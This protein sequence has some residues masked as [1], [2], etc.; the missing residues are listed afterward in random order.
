MEANP[1]EPRYY[2]MLEQLQVLDFALMEL[3]LYLD[4]HPEDLRAI[5]QFNQ[6]TQ[7]SAPGWP[8]NFRSCTA[9]CRTLAAPTPNVRGNG[10]RVLGLGRYSGTLIPAKRLGE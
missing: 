8:I 7:E 5:E 6:L 3:N 2:E 1:C 9:R 10:A 4:T